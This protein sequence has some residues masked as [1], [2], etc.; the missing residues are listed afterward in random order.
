MN[1]DEGASRVFKGQEKKCTRIMTF[2]TS[3]SRE[4]RILSVSMF[5]E[6]RPQGTGG[7]LTYKGNYWGN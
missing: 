6:T 1:A 7:G 5:R 3:S 4:K 2:L